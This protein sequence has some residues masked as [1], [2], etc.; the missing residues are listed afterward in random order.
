MEDK[1]KIER[2][3]D[4]VF[5]HAAL[6]AAL[7]VSTVREGDRYDAATGEHVHGTGPVL[8]FR[9]I[10]RIASNLYGKESH[11]D[12]LLDHYL[13]NKEHLDG[14][15]NCPTYLSL[16]RMNRL[17]GETGEFLSMHRRLLVT[18]KGV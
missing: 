13:V 6:H 15:C 3:E 12:R 9:D 16:L 4:A 10:N 2:A 7:P 17:K 1:K 14:K 5:N 11:S 18:A 8:E